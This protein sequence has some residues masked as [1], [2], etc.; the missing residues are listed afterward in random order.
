MK[1]FILIFCLIGTEAFADIKVV[2]GDSLEINGARIRMDGIDA[3]EFFQTCFNK[4][5]EEY[6]CGQEATSHLQQLI[7]NEKINCECL[8]K[9]DKYKRKICECFAN[10]ISLNLAMIQD[11]HAR[12]YRSDRYIK[13]ENDAKQK[14]KGIWQGKHMRPAL[15]RV[16]HHR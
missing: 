9:P 13:A 11:G 7:G 14:Q 8:P 5:N 2:D 1:K 4:N 3:P 6:S 15:Y 12:A 10:D 16:L